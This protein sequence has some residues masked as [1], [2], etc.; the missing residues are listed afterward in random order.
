MS[1][2]RFPFRFLA[3]LA[4]ALIAGAADTATLPDR[5]LDGLPDATE[6]RNGNGR[7]DPGETDWQNADT[8][9]DGSLDGEEVAG[10]T[11]PLNPASYIPKRLAAWWWDG[12][13]K[14]W[15]A[16]DRGQLPLSGAD[17]GR[18]TNGTFQ[19]GIHF[20]SP[21]GAPLR[22]AVREPNGRLN[23]R[24]DHGSVR[25]WFK[26]DWAWT[27][28]PRTAPRLFEVG[29]FLNTN[30]GWWSWLF[31]P[32]PD[33]P[34]D[35]IRLQFAQAIG[36]Y[37]SVRYWLPLERR[38]WE[39]PY[40]HELTLAY[41]LART[42]LWHNGRLH[43][44]PLGNARAYFGDG[45]LRSNLPPLR[46]LT[47]EGFALGG[48]S[49]GR[50]GAAEG[51][52]DSVETFNYPLGEVE[53]FTRQQLA[54]RVDASGPDGARLQL[55]RPLNGAA[56]DVGAAAAR[57]WALTLWRRE[58][59][60]AEWGEARF[61]NSVAAVWTDESAVPGRAYEYRAQFG[62]SEALGG[63]T[64][65]LTRHFVAG[66]AMPPAHRRGHVIVGV[67]STLQ[68]ALKSDLAGLRTNLVGDGWSVTVLSAPRHDDRNWKANVRNLARFRAALADA[69]RPG[70]TNVVF[71]LGHVV[72]PYSGTDPSDGHAGQTSGPWP[73]DAYHGYSDAA[74]F[75][76][77][78]E[79]RA[80]S[81]GVPNLPEDGRFD[82]NFLVS[83][84]GRPSASVGRAPA[85]GVGRVD[86]AG[87]SVFGRLSEAE[88]IRRYLAKD[89]RYR[90]NRVP[91]A[92][93][94]SAHLGNPA[95][96]T[97]AHS[98]Q[99]FAGA[100]FGVEPG[101]VFS[102]YSLTDPIPADLGVHFQYAA[103]KGGE[104]VA[105]GRTAK[106]FA[107]ADF[108]RPELEVP[109]T[110]RQVW[111]SYACNW[112]PLDP[113]GRVIPQE[114]WLKAS[115][116]WP[117][118]GLATLP[119][120]LWDWAPLGA[121]APLAALMTH[122]FEGQVAILRFQTILG[123]PT[124][125]LHRVTPPANLGASRQGREVTL[126]WSA[127]PDPGCVYFVYRSDD[128]LDGFGEPLGPPTAGLSIVDKPER[129]PA[130]YQVRAA[131]LQPTGSGSFTNLSQGIF[132]SLPRR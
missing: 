87:L 6:D 64:I 58:P 3:A 113:A 104:G 1:R 67:D 91:T 21:A 110:F 40:W 29:T 65:P 52:I 23:A 124:L 19:A 15:K 118:Y 42:A 106:A 49:T 125:R 116:G 48:D 5:D 54:F 57:P 90:E 93:R 30:T 27:N 59:G 81:G 94:V 105:E 107:S 115:L 70:T 24:L 99:S 61:R 78:D 34:P 45:V 76:D 129:L 75:T 97:G 20:P 117:N 13:E 84:G 43:S 51:A 127:S 108:A 111:F 74:G 4:G 14:S 100:A 95:M 82:Q 89:F 119:G 128:G 130:L 120:M 55:V 71:L 132:V 62:Y 44:A 126:S 112:T 38:E 12:P 121:G 26:P 102:G 28:H 47:D 103:G 18:L 10:S 131:R 122:G 11:D 86:F 9:Q 101:A 96:V 56:P 79:F 63:A 37:T 83:S 2:R 25:L 8:D 50:F 36:T 88:L 68:S 77:R 31:R 60:S 7:Q 17:G 33:D 35:V 41:S 39:S 16:G 114:N 53:L 123:D 80:D 22:Y 46:T 85:W 32:Q 66:I 69:A 92:G 73:C 109:V 98:A 72:I